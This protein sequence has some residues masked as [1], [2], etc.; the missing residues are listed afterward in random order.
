MSSLRTRKPTL[1]T[2][3]EKFDAAMAPVSDRSS[4]PI[5]IRDKFAATRSELNTALIERE[6]EIDLTLTALLAQESILLI[7]PPGTAKSMLC[8][9]VAHWTQGNK[10]TYLLTKYTDPNEI[11][12][13]YDLQGYKAG[14]YQRLTDGYLP[15][16]D[17]A[18]LDEVFKGSSAILNTT[19]RAINERKFRNGATDLNLPLRLVIGA[20]N[21]VPPPES[22]K[23]LHAIFDRFLIRH[24]IKATL[25]KGGRHRLLALPK[26]GQPVNRDHTPRLSTS[27]TLA[28]LDIASSEAL[29]IPWSD[30]AEH[31]LDQIL[32]ELQTQGVIPT[33]RRQWK[34]V[35]VVQAYGWL[36]GADVINPEHL[37]ILQDVLWDD[38]SQ[39]KLAH[40]T[41]GKIANPTGLE[42]NGLIAEMDEI[43]HTLNP[44]D[45]ASET[46]AVKRLGEIGRKFKELAPKNRKAEKAQETIIKEIQRIRLGRFDLLDG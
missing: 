32:D 41:I 20:S 38:P 24:E 2:V 22:M 8:E 15:W 40:D 36:H 23:E 14:V 21:E 18:F 37:E 17:I 7:G 11:F 10:F 42:V 31:A 5:T 16:A 13:P 4:T 44:N 45:M 3:Q 29:A 25:T 39:T 12:G 46:R 9:A 19:L 27:L 43:I 28:E 6:T 26:P 34:S 35:R 30:D 1:D 33:Q